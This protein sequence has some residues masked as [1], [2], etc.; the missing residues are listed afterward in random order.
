MVFQIPHIIPHLHQKQL[1]LLLRPSIRSRETSQ[2]ER[3]SSLQQTLHLKRADKLHPLIFGPWRGRNLV[4]Y[5][6]HVFKS[7][8]LEVFLEIIWLSK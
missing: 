2:T 4:A 3:G 6:C 1:R 5:F 7:G 8:L